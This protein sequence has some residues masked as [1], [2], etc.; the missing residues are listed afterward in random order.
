[1]LTCYLELFV[2]R[3]F[4]FH[5]Y[6]HPELYE[7]LDLELDL[8]D[9]DIIQ[10]ERG[11]LCAKKSR[12]VITGLAKDI[13]SR[14]KINL[15]RAVYL[16]QH[17]KDY[18]VVVYENDSTDGT[19]ELLDMMCVVNGINV[20]RVP[21]ESRG[22]KLHAPSAI[23]SGMF[24]KTRID[25]MT[26]YRNSA[27][28]YIRRRYNNYDYILV[29]DLDVQGP[30]SSAGLFH[31]L[32][33]EGQW[34]GISSNGQ[35]VIPGSFGLVTKTYDSLAWANESKMKC[36]TAEQSLGSIFKDM[37]RMNWDI[38]TSKDD[39]V[40]VSSAF[41]GAT[42]YKMNSLHE[43]VNYQNINGCEHLGLSYN[44]A[45]NGHGRIFCNRLWRWYVGLQ[46]PR[47]LSLFI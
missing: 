18:R 47:K 36:H 42:I 3:E 28:D 11:K 20:E 37:I 44:M 27:L 24:S 1:M 45:K 13:Y 26:H 31:S 8:S 6:W 2:W 34:D 17:F 5:N 7:G 16:G 14:L 22:C 29:M 35:G 10:I 43:G 21:C 12:I 32:G 23:D 4:T 19:A 33:Y 25:K 40:P 39:M 41:N 30:L 38:H 15:E 9:S 46:G